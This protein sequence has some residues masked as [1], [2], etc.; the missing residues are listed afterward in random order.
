MEKLL[1]VG[2]TTSFKMIFEIAID[3]VWVLHLDIDLLVPNPSNV[4]VNGQLVED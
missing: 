4:V 3:Q 1:K 2:I